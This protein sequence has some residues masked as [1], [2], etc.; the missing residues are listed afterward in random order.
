MAQSQ[1]WHRPP[2]P[3][4]QGQGAGGLCAWSIDACRKLRTGQPL[5][6][7]DR[8]SSAARAPQV[9]ELDTVERY[10][11]LLPPDEL[12]ACGS[13]TDRHVQQHRIVSRGLLRETL[14]LYLPG[15]PEP[16]ELR[17]VRGP[18]GKPGLVPGSGAPPICFNASN[19]DDCMGEG[20]LPESAP[21]VCGRVCVGG[22]GG[23]IV[24]GKGQRS[25][26]PPRLGA[27]HAEGPEHWPRSRFL[28]SRRR[29]RHGGA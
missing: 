21:C 19:T 8:R 15:R 27:M 22:R 18:H 7:G 6:L 20:C 3:T 1:A 2:A 26:H 5:A 25:C 13:A 17:L 10:A 29:G 23:E 14:A 16:R 9:R 4:G 11:G 12:A 24:R 28:T